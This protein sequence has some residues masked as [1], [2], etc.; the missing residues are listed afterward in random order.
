M[1]SGA[2]GFIGQFLCLQ[3]ASKSYRVT[4]LTRRPWKFSSGIENLVLDDLS[5][6]ASIRSVLEEVGVVIHLAAR[7]HVMNESTRDSLG[8]YQKINVENTLA[9]ARVAAESGVKRFIYLSSAK[10]NGEETNVHKPFTADDVPAPRDPYAIS[11]LEAEISLLA[12]GRQ[13]GMEVVIIRPPLVYGPGVGANF[14]RMMRW[15]LL[16]IPMPFGSISNKRSMVAL[17]NLANLILICV[18]KPA[19]A[20]QVFLVSDGEDISLPQLLRKMA[21][22]LGVPSRI[23]PFPVSFLWITAK[24][25]GRKNVVQRL[26][27][28]LQLD[29]SKTKKLLGWEPPASLDKSLSEVARWYLGSKFRGLK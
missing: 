13:T 11:K 17:E 21:A 12:L 18:S 29:I 26:C 20:N 7:V 19:A 2:N 5:N 16:G 22:V 25:L 14:A 28:S 27:G 4:A 24:M 6:V 8:L 3:A 9:L 15:V 23:F 10:V 1:I